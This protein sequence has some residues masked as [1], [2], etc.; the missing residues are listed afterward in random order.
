[1]MWF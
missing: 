1:L